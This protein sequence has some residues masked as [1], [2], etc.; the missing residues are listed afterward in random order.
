[1]TIHIAGR[2]LAC[3][4]GL[5]VEEALATLRAGAGKAESRVL[6]GGMGGEF[7]Y[8][9]IPLAQPDWY[10]RARDIVLRVADEAG[11]A[12]ARDGAL[13]VATSS[14]DIGATAPADA[15]D[16]AGDYR[17]FVDQVAAWLQWRG[18]VHAVSTACTSS[19]N[20]L[21][22]AQAML[23]AGAVEQALVL[24]IELDNCLTLGGFAALQLLSRT[25]CKPFG[26]ER[27]GL[28]LGEAVAAL[29]L[30]TR[31][32]ASWRLRGGA[33][34]IDGSQPTGASASALAAMYK[35]TLE[36]S[37]LAASD[38]DL[39]KVQAAG[40]PGNDEAE[41]QALRAAFGRVPSLVSFKAAI[42]HTM[43]ASGAAEISLLTACLEQGAWPTV[44]DVIDP[45]L[46]VALAERAPESVRRVIATILGFGGS[47]A[48]VVLERT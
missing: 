41:A 17:I 21:L 23:N 4:L 15:A 10:Q 33:N 18:P 22:A 28:V 20:A 34:V 48:S 38:I 5:N 14:F 30:S 42:G 25:G 45:D 44:A 29:R 37:G 6:P 27:D 31:E 46:G 35:R 7:P 26:V 47:H 24:G 36:S 9:A 43:G 16:Y 1:M 2:G 40:S 3:S 13:F 8:H 11:A 12:Q 39:I 32:G 19:L